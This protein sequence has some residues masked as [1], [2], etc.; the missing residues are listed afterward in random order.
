MKQ[1]RWGF[2]CVSPKHITIPI[3]ARLYYTRQYE[4]TARLVNTNA[5]ATSFGNLEGKTGMF[6][7][8]GC[9]QKYRTP[10]RIGGWGE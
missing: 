5:S 10:D 3:K 6:Y 9:L 1:S 7:K 8:K 4:H 2:V